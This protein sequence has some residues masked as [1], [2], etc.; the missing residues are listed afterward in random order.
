MQITILRV[1][2]KPQQFLKWLKKDFCFQI[3]IIFQPHP[4]SLEDG[5]GR[6]PTLVLVACWCFVLFCFKTRGEIP[7]F[8]WGEAETVAARRL[9]RL[10]GP[11]R[12]GFSGLEATEGGLL[13]LRCLMTGSGFICL[14]FSQRGW[15]ADQLVSLDGGT[16]FALR[17]LSTQGTLWASVP[18]K[19]EEGAHQNP[20]GQTT[21]LSHVGRTQAWVRAAP[22]GRPA[23]QTYAE[24]PEL[25]RHGMTLTCL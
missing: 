16:W 8:L 19:R 14:S 6:I 22:S 4:L 18:G 7:K 23:A 2:A 17:P 1:A 15:W 9:G 12:A 24:S 20:L 13:P 11:R 5:A 10:V 25:E 3:R 21:A